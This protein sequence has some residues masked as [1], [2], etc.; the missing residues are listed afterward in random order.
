MSDLASRLRAEALAVPPTADGG[1]AQRIR[2]RLPAAMPPAPPP[3]RFPARLAAAA[4]LA[5]TLGLAWLMA[6]ATAPPAAVQTA[7]L[8]PTPPTPPTLREML[9]DAG[10]AMPGAT[11]DGEIAALGAD[12]AAVAR[13][14]RSAVPF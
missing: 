5:A 7:V 3:L 12:L 8:P 13:A 6:G 2:D 1:L 9:R 4:V 11:V 10:S 14:V